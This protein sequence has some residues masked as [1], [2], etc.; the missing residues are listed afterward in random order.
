MTLKCACSC[1][2]KCACSCVHTVSINDFQDG[3]NT[4][5][6]YICRILTNDY[7]ALKCIYMISLFT[8]IK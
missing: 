4:Q 7:Q 3:V 8:L 1:V 6:L 2:Q 5:S